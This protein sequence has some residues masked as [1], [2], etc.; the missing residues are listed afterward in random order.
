MKI[1]IFL[2]AFCLSFIGAIDFNPI[3][4]FNLNTER[5]FSDTSMV[6]IIEEDSIVKDI[7]YKDTLTEKINEIISAAK[8]KKPYFSTVSVLCWYGSALLHFSSFPE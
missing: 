6:Y 3:L 4:A 7:I 1:I 5:S 2:F 8:N